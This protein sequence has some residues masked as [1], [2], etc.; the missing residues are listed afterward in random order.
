M[1]LNYTESNNDSI[2]KDI[3]FTSPLIKNMSLYI[4]QLQK[5]ICNHLEYI[6]Q[7][8][9][10]KSIQRFTFD[11]QYVTIYICNNYSI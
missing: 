9:E 1:F 5:V 6:E 7:I 10:N 11:K 8:T 4:E 2:L 3:Q